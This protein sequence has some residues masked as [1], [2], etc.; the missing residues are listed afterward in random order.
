MKRTNLRI[1]S[2]RN[3][4]R[5][6]RPP[7]PPCRI[8]TALQTTQSKY[9]QTP[10]PTLQDLNGTTNNTVQVQTDPRSHPAGS[11]RHYKQHSPSTDRPPVP[12]CRISTALQTT[13][14]KYRQTPGPTLQDL[15]GTT[16]NTVQVQTDPRSHPA[17]SQRH[18]K[19][20]SPSTDRP[21]VPPCRISTALQTTQS[22]Y[23]QTPGPTLQDLHS[24]TNNTV[25][26]QTDPRS[27]PAGSL[28]RYKQH[29]PST[30]RPPVPPCRISTALQTTQSKYRQTPG[31]SLQDL[32]STTN[33]TVQVQTDPRSHPAG[34]LQ[35]YKQHSPSTDRPP[36]PPCRISTALQTTQSKYRQTPGPSLQDLHSTTNNTVQVQTDPRSHP[37]GSQRHYKQHSPSTDRPPVP[38]CRI[39][40]ALQTT[41]SK[42]RQTPG[43]TLQDL[44]STTNNTVQVQTDPRSHPAGSPQH[45]KQ[46]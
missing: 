40:T 6:D 17:G 18:Y 41:Q 33:N 5:T 4:R 12:P 8:S 15:N 23:R 21:P 13:Q 28:Q 25:Q 1:R 27:H 36:V 10:G 32:H 20:H 45:Y 44:H 9:R 37:A 29:S 22:K 39:S 43:P 3:V 7:V 24:T 19:Q 42:Y 2:R 14:S 38:P 30:D 34:S 46:Q 26:V 11:Q 35:H 31:P 16:N